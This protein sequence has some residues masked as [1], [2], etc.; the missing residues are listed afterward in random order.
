MMD[1]ME[2]EEN[3][4]IKN[5]ISVDRL[6]PPDDSAS[7]D[8]FREQDISPRIGADYQ[9]EIPEPVRRSD[10][11]LI[12]RN[13]DRSENVAM[14]YLVG[15]PIP[16]L[17]ISQE[18]ENTKAEKIKARQSLNPSRKGRGES[19][20]LNVDPVNVGSLDE[21][22]T[23]P[24]YSDYSFVPLSATGCW[25]DM[26]TSSFL[27]GLYIFEKNFVQLKKFVET[28]SLGEIM[29][30]Y[31]GKFYRSHEY[32]R[33]SDSR[34]MK[35]RR[36]VFGQK[37]FS[38]L[39]QQEFLSRIFRSVSDDC[40]N[41]LLEVS[42]TFESVDVDTTV[43]NKKVSENIPLEPRNITDSSPE[44]LFVSTES[45]GCLGDDSV[46]Y[47]NIPQIPPD[48]ENDVL[49]E[50]A[51]GSKDNEAS[52]SMGDSVPQPETDLK[53]VQMLQMSNN[54][55]IDEVIMGF[56]DQAKEIEDRLKAEPPNRQIVS[57]YHFWGC[58]AEV[59][60][61]IKRMDDG[62]LAN[63]LRQ[64]LKEKRYLVVMDDMW[65][66]EAWNDLKMSLP[67][68]KK[69]SR[70]LITSRNSKVASERET[71]HRPLLTL[72]ESWNLFNEKLFHGCSCLKELLEIGRLIIRKCKG[73]PLAIVVMAGL[74][75]KRKH[76]LLDAEC[77]QLS[78]INFEKFEL[79]R[80]LNFSDSSECYLSK[81]VYYKFSSELK[82]HIKELV[83]NS[84]KPNCY[85]Q[86]MAADSYTLCLTKIDQ[87]LQENDQF[88]CGWRT[89]FVETHLRLLKV[90]V[91]YSGKWSGEEKSEHFGLD[92]HHYQELE[93]QLSSSI[94]YCDYVTRFVFA[95]VS[96]KKNK[97]QKNEPKLRF[98]DSYV[99]LKF[100]ANIATTCKYLLSS[101]KIQPPITD[102]LVF[103]RFADSVKDYVISLWMELEDY[104][105]CSKQKDSFISSKVEEDYRATAQRL[106][107]FSSLISSLTEHFIDRHELQKFLVRAGAV[108]LRVA[109]VACDNQTVNRDT[110]SF[111]AK[112]EFHL[113]NLFSIIHSKNVRE[114]TGQLL[115]A[116]LNAF[117]A[118]KP[119]SSPTNPTLTFEDPVESF[120]N[121]CQ[122]VANQELNTILPVLDHLL[123][124]PLVRHEF[125]LEVKKL[126]ELGFLAVTT[127]ARSLI[128]STPNVALSKLCQK[129]NLIKSEIL[130]L[131]V[132][133]QK[134]NLTIYDIGQAGSKIN[135]FTFLSEFFKTPEAD[136]MLSVL[137]NHETSLKFLE[138]YCLEMLQ[139]ILISLRALLNQDDENLS[140]ISGAVVSEAI[141]LVF[142]L[143]G[144]SEKVECM[145]LLP[146]SFS[147][148]FK[149]NY[150]K[151]R[152]VP[153][154]C[155][156]LLVS[157]FPKSDGPVYV[158]NLLRNVREFLESNLY[159]TSKFLKDQAQVLLHEIQRLLSLM[160]NNHNE[161]EDLQGE[162]LVGL[163]YEAEYIIINLFEDEGVPS[164][165]KQL[166][167]LNAISA[168]KLIKAEIQ[169]YHHHQ[170]E[171]RH[172]G[173]ILN[174]VGHTLED[175]NSSSTDDVIVGF[176]DRAKHIEDQL[177]SGSPQRQA[178][179]IVG[180]GGVGKTTLARK[181]YNS[182]AIQYHFRKRAWC[183]VSQ[184]YVKKKLLLE[185]LEC[186]VEIPQK[187]EG[188]TADPKKIEEMDDDEI[189]DTLRRSL[190]GQRYL[191]VMDDIWSV[192]AW[193]DLQLSLPDDG[194]ASRILI[195]SRNFDASLKMEP[196]ILP[197]LTVEESWNLFK[198]RLFHGGS[199]PEE[200]LE[201][202]KLIVEYGKGLP[203]AVVVIAGFLEKIEKRKD[204][205]DEI[206][207]NLMSYI[208]HDHGDKQIKD[209][210]EF[211]YN[212]LPSHLKPCFLY[213]GTF[214]EDQEIPVQKLK[215]M[216]I[217]EGFIPE[218]DSK[219]LE[220]TAEE[221]LMELISRNLVMEAQ[222]RSSGGIKTCT[223]H[224]MVRYLCLEKAWE[225][226]FMEPIASAYFSNSSKSS[227]MFVSSSYRLC[228]Q[229]KMEH[230][231]IPLKLLSKNSKSLRV[232]D[233]EYVRTGI[234]GLH[235]LGKM[236]CLKYLAVRGWFS[237][238]PSS[239][240]QLVNLE[241]LILRGETEKIEVSTE[242]WS[243]R[244]LKNIHINSISHSSLPGPDEIVNLGNIAT[245][246]LLTIRNP[247]LG[248]N[249][250]RRLT[251]IKKL[252][253]KFQRDLN[254]D[255]KSYVLPAMDTLHQLESL[256][257][258]TLPFTDIYFPS[259][260]SFPTNLKKLTLKRFWLS[261]ESISAIGQ[262]LSNL[263]VLKIIG[264]YTGESM[265]D[266]REG[267][268]RKLKYLKLYKFG[269]ISF[270]SCTSWNASS[271]SFPLLERLVL[272][273]WHNLE[274]VPSSFG[275][276]PTLQMIEMKDCSKLS[277]QLKGWH[278]KNPIISMLCMTYDG[279]SVSD[280]CRYGDDGFIK[281]LRFGSFNRRQN[282]E[283]VVKSYIF[284]SNLNMAMDS[285]NNPCLTK[286]DQ[287]IQ[288]NDQ[289]PRCQIC[290]NSQVFL[291]VNYEPEQSIDHHRD[292]RDFVAQLEFHSANLLK[293][294]EENV[295]EITGIQIVV[296]EW[297]FNSG[298]GKKYM[299]E[300]GKSILAHIEE[301]LGDTAG[302][303][304]CLEILQKS[305]IFMRALL[306][307]ENTELSTIIG[308]QKSN[309]NESEGREGERIIGLIYEAE[310]I[311]TCLFEAAGV[312][313]W[314]KQ[315]ILFNTIAEAKLIKSVIQKYY[316]HHLKEERCHGTI[317]DVARETFKRSNSNSSTD[318]VI[319]GLKDRAKDI[320]DRLT[321]GSPKLQVVSIVGMGGI[322]KT[323]LV[324]KV[325]NSPAIQHHFRDR[326][327]CTV[328]QVYHKRE[329][330]LQILKCSCP[331]ELLGVGSLIVENCKGL[332]LAIVV[333]AALLEKVEKR[334]YQWEEIAQHMM[335]HLAHDDG[336]SQIMLI[337][338]LSYN[339]LPSHLKPCFLYF[340][341]F[342]EDQ[343]VPVQK[344]KWLWIAEGFVPKT[345]SKSLE[346]TA[347]EY[348]VELIGRNLVMEAQRRS[349]GGVKT[350]QMH[351]MVRYLCLEKAREQNFMQR[352]TKADGDDLD[353]T[354]SSYRLCFQPN[355]EEHRVPFKLV[356]PHVRSLMVLP[357]KQSTAVHFELKESQNLRVM[358]IKCTRIAA[359][360]FE[361]LEVMRCLKY[362]ALRGKFSTVPSRIVELFN[363]E[364]LILKTDLSRYESDGINV[365]TELWI[366]RK[367]RHVSIDFISHSSLPDP[368]EISNLENIVTLSFLTFGR[369]SRPGQT[370][371]SKLI[372]LKELK[373]QFGGRNGA[374]IE[375][376][377][378][379][380][381][382]DALYQLESLHLC[383]FRISPIVFLLC[384][385]RFPPN[386]KKLTLSRFEL[387]WE[388]TSGIGQQFCNLEVLKL[389]DC[390][391][392][393][394]TT[395]NVA[396]GEF[397]NLKCLMIN[398]NFCFKNW[399]ASSDSFP[400]LERLVLQGCTELVEIPISFG[401]IP[402]LQ[403]IEMN[404]CSESA[405]KSALRIYEQQLE[406]GNEEFK[407]FAC[408]T[409]KWSNEDKAKHFGSL[410]S[411]LGKLETQ[412][413]S[414]NLS[415]YVAGF[416]FLETSVNF[417]NEPKLCVE[418]GIHV[419]ANI[420]RAFKYLLSLEIHP[421]S[422]IVVFLQFVDSVHDYILSLGLEL[423]EYRKMYF[424]ANNNYLSD[425]YLDKSHPATAER[426][427]FFRVVVSN[428]AESLIDKE[429]E[430]RNLLDRATALVFRAA[431]VACDI[432][433]ID[434]NAVDYHK[435]ADMLSR[436][437]RFEIIPYE[438]KVIYDE[439]VGETFEALKPSSKWTLYLYDNI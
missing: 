53:E 170:E 341:M 243:M 124:N 195:T 364:T 333:M 191:V 418:G 302:E 289:L 337:L 190:K 413:I 313:L 299:R 137:S 292:A 290:Y 423:Q 165:Y 113:K 108:F 208:S 399:N 81:Y 117:E 47:L 20:S 147:R 34:K 36:C 358:D 408:D 393:D 415:D 15:L 162:R 276:I 369:S 194:K 229:P 97:K 275:E 27:L 55:R 153:Q 298:Y 398:Y 209:I 291:S 102:V 188:F 310:Y 279:G 354:S 375:K 419:Q 79:L 122:L 77:L 167:V 389:T 75:E 367:L 3:G 30:F 224:D 180:M 247:S 241:T 201:V 211:S 335:S 263:E 9:A 411:D 189:A 58:I 63:T 329:L 223:M 4:H 287:F 109:A 282:E 69:G 353:D 135:A 232:L 192:Q 13:V 426:L 116:Y 377:Y 433:I 340:G 430:L 306:D 111:T 26:E 355:M 254:I 84:L 129:L 76:R 95:K 332:P 70:I 387:P 238:V 322:G 25:T 342:L 115:G 260:F 171:E 370:F 239:I 132:H 127:K 197:F 339:H 114:I 23:K 429:E 215:W 186:I 397:P 382:M 146:K 179:L 286:I 161:R 405:N 416:V 248:E 374:D 391:Q 378:V 144:G 107:Y 401:E 294:I 64:H 396:E 205:W 308:P 368:D 394:S 89:R 172:L 24:G 350:C 52:N 11:L 381:A 31:Y 78:N 169:E 92:D 134:A 221:Y 409:G 106:G 230:D 207:L 417:G 356:G 309:N 357:R 123:A 160:Q 272:Q 86:N 17:L 121:L 267:E 237:W 424:P 156:G 338:E 240:V 317:L 420:A 259:K 288:E 227:S 164:W 163:I 256:H 85:K 343:Q 361:E 22:A 258:S 437:L 385:F 320:E 203:L 199:C 140:K 314:Y 228:F 159:N 220:E 173:S 363:L 150:A 168:A 48:F 96:K 274:E 383:R 183:T 105:Q 427:R 200:L 436:I 5:E 35:T 28:K 212:H 51:A 268:F 264:Y 244:K 90:L 349:R 324:K 60:E 281:G 242:L 402:T 362:L 104:I 438:V 126:L 428:F 373:C 403:M 359:R 193:N 386:L 326:A 204:L 72:E 54:S 175:P 217:G 185:I 62:D 295:K 7:C 434:R 312:P 422:S 148:K 252:K 336:D 421:S 94:S 44:K 400:S 352:I 249:F 327:W 130:V 206:A 305:L 261:W 345:D 210:L 234:V 50:D 432:Q 216:W 38:G 257:L 318:D 372:G 319:V 120:A 316:S 29:S 10:Y 1:P 435:Q 270:A 155:P 73:L 143:G 296:D 40:K 16:V 219:S 119:S 91:C 439:V 218:T 65:S 59:T 410:P 384:N 202:G 392:L 98:E 166:M 93:S 346:E 307:Q 233:A 68:D 136:A 225:V 390:Y 246:S 43:A 214:S 407:V 255:H 365:P 348:L 176:E 14:E 235:D 8:L 300:I 182:L 21:P 184:V 145:N 32:Y 328:S 125:P 395:W 157:N 37:I 388:S 344:L 404:D 133:N 128:A 49:M 12:S 273:D 149:L 371:L 45:K 231:R 265:W 33:W 39:R 74:L 347:E 301:L 425:Y 380:P 19:G 158:D 226:N 142:S 414:N 213:L 71:Y 66:M 297:I 18:H 56:D 271:D 2:L 178:V 236:H 80:S 269:L 278:F 406:Y 41:A 82:R 283:A 251:G 100:Q 323:T 303:R 61:K 311:I 285:Y 376:N 280:I 112:M 198:E 131:E 412:L 331:E 325:Y 262:H 87:F 57:I 250:L 304:Y 139:K 67:D 266:V 46:A 154:E 118:R 330:L 152:A 366:M 315:M 177:K 88:P 196:Y 284:L 101:K 6:L 351:D 222:R 277:S 245:L 181:V 360:F 141:N 187:S 293:I 42:K 103:S 174:V 431:I 321:N 138:R 110:S 334:K 99:S 253:C 379:F 83:V 151:I